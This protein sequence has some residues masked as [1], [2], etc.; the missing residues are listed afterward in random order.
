MIYPKFI[1][2]GDCIA[3]PAPSDGSCCEEDIKRYQNA[4][5]KFE[6]MGFEINLSKNI[7][8]SEMG[9]SA[10]AKV[11]AEELNKMFEDDNI[12]MI[13]CATGGEFLI[14]MLSYVDFEK[15]VQNPKFIEGFS[16]P[17]GILFPVTTKYD[18]ATIYGKNFSSFG[19]DEYHKS[20]TDNIEILNGNLIKQ[21]S[22][23][24]FENERAQ[25]ITGLEGYNLTDKVCWKILGGLNKITVKGR[26]FAGC[27]DLID[28]L[29]GT[30]YDGAVDFSEKYKND[31]IIWC[32]DNCDLSK[33]QLIRTLWKFNELG[34]FKN[35]NAIVFGRNGNENSYL[36]YDMEHCLKDSVISKLNIPIIYNADISHKSPCLTIINGA[37]AEI[38]C[39]SGKGNITIYCY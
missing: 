4:K 28:V 18:I 39:E 19:M 30:K 22:F 25:R 37:I 20:L 14:E 10:S 33:E 15:L 3:V 7:F 29:A 23:E 13:I 5:R 27:I 12:D 24:F 8:N 11:R 35:T 9:R 31:G 6:N 34:Y 17:T 26:I 21:N 1:N 32:F 16:D 2:K 36:K 38:T